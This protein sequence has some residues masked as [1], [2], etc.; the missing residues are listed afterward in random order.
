M[1]E[2]IIKKVSKELGLTYRALGKNI[3][4]SENTIRQSASSNK[5]SIPLQKAIELYIHNLELSKEL[6]ELNTLKIIIKNIAKD[7]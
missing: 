3:G 5:I 1:E 7:I 2:N 6:N 4:Y